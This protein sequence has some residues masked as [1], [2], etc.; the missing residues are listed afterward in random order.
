MSGL[1]AIAAKAAIIPTFNA[2]ALRD[3]SADVHDTYTWHVNTYVEQPA[4]TALRLS[5]VNAVLQSKTPKACL[6]A[7]FGYGKTAS[8]IGLWHACEQA[9]LLVVPP[10]ACGSFTELALAIYGW[11]TFVLPESAALLH[12]AHDRF[13]T[14]SAESLARH[15]ERIFG[16]PFD[17]AITAIRDKLERGYLDFDD[18]SVNLLAFIEQA[19]A[20]AQRAGY[21]GLVVM[22]D[23]FQQFLGNAHKGVLIALRQL[24]WGLRVRK[25]PFGLVLTMDP[26]TERTLAD[27]AGDILHRIKDD[28][29]YLDIRHI[30]D[31]DFPARLWQQYTS[32]LALNAEEQHAIDRPT[33]EALG[34]LC[35][36]D[37]LSNGPRTVI[38]VL[39]RA[40]AQWSSERPTRYTPIHLIDDFLN[41]T[42]RFDGDRGIV[43]ALVS[44]LL[45]FPYF[46][47]SGERAAAL[48]LIAAFPRGCPEQV[49]ERYGLGQAWRQLND[50]LRGEIVTETEEGLALIELQ[51]VGRPANRLNILLRRYWMQIT[52]QQLFAEDAVKVFRDLVLPL[53]FPAKVHDLNG[54]RGVSEIELMADNTYAGIIEGTSSPAFPLRRI[55]I[56]VRRADSAAELRSTIDDVDLYLEFAI[57]VR[58]EA[59]SSVII[60]SDSSHV[61][62]TLA[63][64]RTTERGL[65]GSISWIAHYLNPHP[66]SPA[67]VLSLLRYLEREQLDTLP[68]RDRTRIEDTLSRLREWLLSEL[69]PPPLFTAAGVQVISSGVSALKEFFFQFFTQRWP[70]YQGLAQVQTWSTLLATYQCVLGRVTPAA[71][72]GQEPVTGSKGEIAALFEQTRHAGFDKFV[73]QYGSLLQ[74]ELWQGD[75]AAVRLL[76]HPAEIRIVE[77]VRRHGDCAVRTI[78]AGL[79]QEGFAA[80]EAEQIISLA[81][82][83]GLLRRDGTRLTPTHTPTELEIDTRLRELTKRVQTLGAIATQ[84]SALLRPFDPATEHAVAAAWRLDQAEQQISALE[85]QAAAAM[86]AHRASSRRQVMQHLP[87]LEQELPEAPSGPV[88]KHLAAARKMLNRE[89]DKLK[90]PAEAFVA[91]PAKFSPSEIETLVSEIETWANTA[92]YYADWVQFGRDLVWLQEALSRI[93]E[94]TH[95]IEE[96]RDQCDRLS[97]EARAVAAE[98]GL[99]GFAEI[100]RLRAQLIGLRR[101]FREIVSERRATYERIAATITE[102]VAHLFDL[103]PAVQIPAY[104]ADNEEQSYR[105]LRQSVTT[106]IRRTLA[107]LDV[108][109]AGNQQISA[110]DKKTVATLR[111]QIRSLMRLSRDPD[112]LFN[113]SLLSLRPNIAKQIR[114]LREQIATITSPSSATTRTRFNLVEALAV[115]RSGPAD[116]ATL[117]ERMNDKV[118]RAELLNDLLSLYKQGQ[119]RLIVDLPEPEDAKDY[120]KQVPTP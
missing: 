118:S 89:R 107:L 90:E 64:N 13:L 111:R 96:L 62:I 36:R 38:N 115:L 66:I 17:Q 119:L 63:V 53:L 117:L 51:R 29:L 18:V 60:H 87:Q 59:E 20:I 65:S 6:V 113:D 39:Q 50:D 77:Q 100:D 99:K 49:A 102:T 84:L 94:R 43:P 58:P 75:Q 5:F 93:E 33:L 31:R 56:A 105:L 16:I 108:G 46:Q 19:T 88:H 55:A 71:R 8:A 14:N 70:N 40:A 85:Q 47:R 83:R 2:R 7:P 24:V 97:R 1:L 54:W 11:L 42:I 78:Y 74:L 48:K 103:P 72:V 109:L 69:F 3:T 22:I 104:Q 91:D 9:G 57:D 116:V 45:S 112:Q 10:V 21:K 79:R 15:D 106:T 44:E 92:R 82:A 35:E 67:V 86:Q 4:L 73:R 101:R 28:G 37:D 120:S 12:E 76:P 41:G 110:E 61:L 98:R 25:L 27:R 34:Q 52:D 95:T 81:V 26:D 80:A 30:Y 114:T 32:A 68:E 23:E